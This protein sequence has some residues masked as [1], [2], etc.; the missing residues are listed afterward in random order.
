MATVY[1]IFLYL[2]DKEVM[3]SDL[4]MSV[5]PEDHLLIINLNNRKISLLTTSIIPTIHIHPH[6]MSHR[7]KLIELIYVAHYL[8]KYLF[9]DV[10]LLLY[11]PSPNQQPLIVSHYCYLW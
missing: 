4:Y 8:S 5:S 6:F 3:L 11:Q 10:L 7:Q 9:A 2:Y 1:G